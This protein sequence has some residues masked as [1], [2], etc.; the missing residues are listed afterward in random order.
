MRFKRAQGP[1]I[2]PGERACGAQGPLDTPRGNLNHHHTHFTLIPPADF[3]NFHTNHTILFYLTFIYSLW[4]S[5][6]WLP[7]PPKSNPRRERTHSRHCTCKAGTGTP[8]D[9]LTPNRVG[10]GPQPARTHRALQ[11]GE[12]LLPCLLI[13][14]LC[15][16]MC[17][18]VV[19]NVMCCTLQLF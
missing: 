18:V 5:R 16:V 7:K 12:F 4:S 2:A 8:R 1:S 19:C 9:E 6:G 17:C 13:C 3:T 10:G 14:L 15:S 11:T